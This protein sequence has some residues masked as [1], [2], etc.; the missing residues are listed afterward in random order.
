VLDEVAAACLDGGGPRSAA[1]EN[2][3]LH[4]KGQ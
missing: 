1:S 2:G 3:Q 4:A